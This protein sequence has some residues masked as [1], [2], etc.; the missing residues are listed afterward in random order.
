MDI[1]NVI[2]KNVIV[3]L[4]PIYSD[5]GTFSGMNFKFKPPTQDILYVT[6]EKDIVREFPETL[7]NEG[8]N[9]DLKSLVDFTSAL[10]NGIS[11]VMY[12]I[13]KKMPNGGELNYVSYSSLEKNRFLKIN[14]TKHF[15]RE[16]NLGRNKVSLSIFEDDED[17]G[18][19]ELIMFDF[20][21]KD[22]QLLFSMITSITTESLNSKPYFIKAV[23]IDAETEK[24]IIDTTIPFVKVANSVVFEDIWLHGQEIF[25]LLFLIDQLNY[26]FEIEKDLNNLNMFYRQTKIVNENGIVYLILKKMNGYGEEEDKIDIKTNKKYY[27]KIPISS[28]VLTIFSMFLSVKMLNLGEFNNISEF[29]ERYES[30]SVFKNIDDIKYH[31]T[32]KE[33]FIGLGYKN[34]RKHGEAMT[35]AIKVKDNAFQLNDE[36]VGNLSLA[37]RQDGKIKQVLD[38][39]DISL[40]DQWP[41]FIEALSISYSRKYLEWGIKS[42]IKKFFITQNESGKWYKYEFNISSSGDNKVSAIL[43][44]DKYLM[45]GKE[46]I[47]VS[48]FRQP[49][50][51]R[52]LYQLLIISLQISSYFNRNEFKIATNK[53]DI[54]KYRYM[55]MKRVVELSKKEEILYGFEKNQDSFKWGIFSNSNNMN[56]EIENEDI[57]LLYISSYFRLLRGDWLP[58]VGNKICIGPDRFLTDIYGEFLLE[59]SIGSGEIWASNIFFVVTENKWNS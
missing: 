42:Y 7:K 10:N 13:R 32:T 4:S 12:N 37:Y 6:S 57:R 25:N 27:L 45:N 22:I 49:L 38:I 59:S 3:S 47:F 46:E 19:N 33:A 9:M 54:I 2:L 30:K 35:L 8:F 21:K 53:K 48:G 51:K 34:T 52:Y 18:K 36:E 43:K 11:T 23:R 24:D 58:F 5:S 41:K 26:E 28:Y 17:F 31:I 50:F 16:K 1:N 14:V 44:I 20:S 29:E 40:K 56:E 39:V 15:F 55:S